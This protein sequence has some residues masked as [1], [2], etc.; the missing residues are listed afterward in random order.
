MRLYKNNKHGP[1]Q[2]PIRKCD[3][4]S[5]RFLMGHGLER[6]CREKHGIPNFCR[7]EQKKLYN[8][9][10]L[11][12]MVIKLQKTNLEL[13]TQNDPLGINIKILNDIMESGNEKIISSDFLDSAGY[14]ILCFSYRI[15]SGDL[16]ELLVVEN[17]TVEWVG[18]N[19][20]ISIFK[21]KR[22]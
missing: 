13:Q 10:K 3:Y 22:K 8:D 11:A 17:F 7:S 14:D 12:D 21:I 6:Y 18:Q 20:S 9:K 19:E 5:E 1:Y 15:P 16:H 4:C 2:G